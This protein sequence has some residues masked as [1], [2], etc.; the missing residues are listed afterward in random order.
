M[1]TTDQ[2]LID[3]IGYIFSESCPENVPDKEVAKILNVSEGKVKSLWKI[4][5]EQQKP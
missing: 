2:E 1:T 5:N 4:I 3:K